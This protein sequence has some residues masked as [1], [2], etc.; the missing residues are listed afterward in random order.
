MHED[1]ALFQTSDHNNERTVGAMPFRTAYIYSDC[2]VFLFLNVIFRQY[3]YL[4]N[5]R[6]FNCY[7]MN[8]C[9][10][11]PQKTG[12]IRIPTALKDQ[13]KQQAPN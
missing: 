5:K 12:N 8:S 10:T 6:Y 9:S 2:I 3:K 11:L 4:N 13:A 7:F 1:L